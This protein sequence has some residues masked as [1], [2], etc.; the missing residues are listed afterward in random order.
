MQFLRFPWAF[1]GLPWRR[2]RVGVSHFQDEALAEVHERDYATSKQEREPIGHEPRGIPAHLF[3]RDQKLDAANTRGSGPLP[4]Q[5]GCL[6][7]L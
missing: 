7:R 6:P 5:L 1:S 4:R 3:V 2:G